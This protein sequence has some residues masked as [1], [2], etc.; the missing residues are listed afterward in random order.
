MR[1]ASGRDPTAPR[2]I[3]RLQRRGDMPKT[4]VI[5]RKAWRMGVNLRLTVA[6]PMTSI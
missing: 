6:G 3:A 5:G 1:A 2:E 4:L